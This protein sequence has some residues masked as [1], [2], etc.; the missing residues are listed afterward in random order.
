MIGLRDHSETSEYRIF[1]PP[2]T[3]KTTE[4]ARHILHA[5]DRF[6]EKSVL[7]TSFS[8]A[9]AAELAGRDTPLGSN[10]IGTLHSHCFH[11]LGQPDI[12]EVSIEGWNRDNPQFRITPVERQIRIDGEDALEDQQVRS[13][14]SLL[15]QLNRC[16]GMMLSPEVWPAPIRD[17]ATR[18]ERHKK[19]SRSL[20]FCDLIERARRDLLSAP[21]NPAVLVVDEAQDLNR[22]QLALIRNWSRNAEYLVLAGDDDQAIYTWAGVTSDAFLE[23]MIPD[24]HTIFLTDSRRIPTTVHQLAETLIRRV[25]HRQEKSYKPR[26]VPGEVRRFSQAGYRSPEYAILKSVEGHLVLGQ[27]IMFLATCSY[28]LQPLIAVLRKNGIPFHNP[29]RKSN[30]F[31][32]PLRADSRKSCV[33]RLNRLLVGHPGLLE[34]YRPWRFGD[35]ALWSEWLRE[36]DVL[37]PGALKAIAI[38]PVNQEVSDEFLQTVFQPDALA[39]LRA[40]LSGSPGSLLNWW[41]DGLAPEFRDRIRFPAE[42]ARVRGAPALTQK[43]QVIVGTIHSVKGGQAD[44]VYLFPDLSQAAAAQNGQAGAPRDSVI[45]TFYVGA[46]RAREI[47]YICSPEGADRISL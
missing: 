41:R 2:G 25:S 22:M 27:T 40:A 33:H 39:Q 34:Q 8:K 35:L 1:G 45:R 11:G 37:M 9:T 46:T 38:N 31:W 15:Q 3:G 29:H 36:G 6:G 5:V 4:L 23:P 30:G 24:D 44:V 14:D 17:F 13:G 18:W 42:I 16:R 19:A 21:G 7:A 10:Q 12:A 20:D 43:P 28:M 26:T 32:N 47:L